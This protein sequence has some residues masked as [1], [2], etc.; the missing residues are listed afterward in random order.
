M[1]LINRNWTDFSIQGVLIPEAAQHIQLTELL[2][3]K[4]EY[5]D[6]VYVLMRCY[7]IN[8]TQAATI[9]QHIQEYNDAITC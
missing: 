6:A 4:L 5:I 3:G 9:Y 7:T 1:P 8:S 2:S